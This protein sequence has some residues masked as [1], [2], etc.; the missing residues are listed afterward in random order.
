MGYG[1]KPTKSEAKAAQDRYAKDRPKPFRT[2][3]DKV[4]KALSD[5][6][7]KKK[8]PKKDRV[9]TKSKAKSFMESFKDVNKK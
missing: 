5:K 6:E 3:F 4:Q 8:K 9:V 2:L 7:K 1:Y